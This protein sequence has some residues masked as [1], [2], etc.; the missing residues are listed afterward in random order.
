MTKRTQLLLVCAC[1][2]AM[3]VGASAAIPFFG[4]AVVLQGDGVT[5]VGAVTSIENLAINNNGFWFIEVDTNGADTNTDGAMLFGGGIG[6]GFSL[7]LREGQALGAPT[8]A[9][10][11]SFD[12]VSINN[13]QHGGFNFFLDGTTGTND[14]SGVFFDSSL[15][16]QEGTIS[17]AAGFSPGTPYI[18]WFET[19]INDSNQIL[20]MSSVDDP[21]IPSTVDRALV[22]ANTDGSGGLVSEKVIVKEGDM[23]AGQGVVE[24]GTGPHSFAFNNAGQAMFVADL[25]GATTG[26]GV[27]AISD[28]DTTT[29]VAQEGT[30]SGIQ[31][32]NWGSLSTSTVMAMNDSGDW[33]MRATLAGDTTSDTVIVSSA[34]LVAQEG[35]G[36]ASIGGFVFTS[37]GTGPVDIDRFG[38]VL[39]YG[40]WD[41]PDTTIDTGLFINDML[42]VQE[43]VTTF[44]GVVIDTIASGQDSF[45][46]SE[47]GRWILFEGTLANGVS[48]AF[49]VYIV[50]APGGAALL[51]LVGVAAIRRRR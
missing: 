9:T 3:S 10:I 39:Y 4:G 25:D 8:G 51:G 26:D 17:T 23:I 40:D 7:F 36:N 11:D 1:G 27:V 6:N 12:G 33:A 22:V 35:S 37:F 42:V 19:K 46:M 31:G 14:D 44:D 28:G 21:N 34:G 47:N 13:D 16:I 45:S 30:A 43:G 49:G 15:V 41:D 29:V 2:G 5:G 18:G 48:G 24:L 20:M 38:N 50:P 32:R